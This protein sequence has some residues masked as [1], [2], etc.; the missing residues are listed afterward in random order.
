MMIFEGN[1]NRQLVHKMFMLCVGLLSGCTVK[2]IQ[3]REGKQQ[4]LH[5]VKCIIRSGTCCDHVRYKKNIYILF[6]HST[7]HGHAGSRVPAVPM[8]DTDTLGF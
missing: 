6:F 5:I 7:P 8:S 3:Y 4:P 1:K 2:F